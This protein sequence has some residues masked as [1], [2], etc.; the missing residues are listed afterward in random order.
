VPPNSVVVGVPGQVLSP[1]RPRST[2][3]PDLDNSVVPDLVGDT[4]ASLLTRVG[5]LE[6]AVN[7]QP[8]SNDIHP[9]EAGV[10]RGEDFSI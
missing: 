3:Q 8:S 1:S 9:P 4:L 6:T 5:R 7:G 2:K 10:W